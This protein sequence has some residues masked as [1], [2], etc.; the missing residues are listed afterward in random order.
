MGNAEQPYNPP[1]VSVGA[2]VQHVM[3][4]GQIGESFVNGHYTDCT[5]QNTA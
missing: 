1:K 3:G 5:S 4:V 2:G